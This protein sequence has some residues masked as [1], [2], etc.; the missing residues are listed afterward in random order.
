[1]RD[2]HPS[3]LEIAEWL[4][5][6]SEGTKGS[7]IV[8]LHLARCA[9]CRELAQQIRE[10]EKALADPDTWLGH[11]APRPDPRMVAEAGEV[12]SEEP[13]VI[14][15]EWIDGLTDGTLEAADLEPPTASRARGLLEEAR[16]LFGREPSAA[17][18]LADAALAVAGRAK[19]IGGEQRLELMGD[20]EKD[21]ANAS[22]L[23]GR[24]PEALEA[25]DRATELYAGLTVNEPKLAMV[26]YVRATVLQEMDRLDEASALA[27]RAE[28][29][30]EMYGYETRAHHARVLQAE[31]LNLRG[32]FREARAEYL[33]LLEAA[34]SDRERARM[35]NDL[36]SVLVDLGEHEQAR[37]HLESASALY[38]RLGLEAA[39][40][41][42][43][44]LEARIS[45]SSGN[46][47]EGIEQ[48]REIERGF[49]RLQMSENAALVALDVVEGL[50]ALE[51]HA[52][53]KETA[54]RLLDHFVSAGS[55][56]SARRAFAYLR[57]AI[58][59]D[60][61]TPDLVRYVRQY[62]RRKSFQP[63][64]VFAPP[65]PIS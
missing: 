24:F 56:G 28:K 37:V 12:A 19:G 51:I 45:L 1:M 65:P 43:R 52:S 57:E 25:L 41:R 38:R 63:A 44:W 13:E 15:P 54:Q 26:D 17:L 11:L 59:H 27:A 62:M 35:H 49:S 33:R 42:L 53:V 5:Q 22:R 46:L 61:A 47:G 34:S 39:E 64:L 10:I 60:T 16:A 50:L 8:A 2:A 21:R 23:M 29:V 4:D 31:V 20:A 58:E 48:L 18:I 30:F 7:G 36:A 3:D 55:A 40:L 14:P 6:E 9:D 32:M